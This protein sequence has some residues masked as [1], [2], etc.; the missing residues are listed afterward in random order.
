M[1]ILVTGG[2]GFI[3]SHVVDAYVALGHEVVVMDD[4]SSGRRENINQKAKVLAVDI[5]ATEVDKIFEDE[6][7][8]AI[9][10]HAA[11]IHVG[12]SVADPAHDAEINI[13]GTINLMQA[14]VKVGTIK[15]VIF[16]STGGAMYGNKQTPFVET[17]MPA[18]LSPYGVS[19]RAAE[20]YLNFYWEQYHIPFVALR[21]ANVYGPRQNPY[22]EA[23]VVAIFCEQLLRGQRTTI[24]GDGKQ[25]RDYVFV[26]D[27]VEANQQALTA[28]PVGVFNIGTGKE[29]DVN[30]IYRLVAE[31]LTSRLS[32]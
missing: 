29:T 31:A 18:P 20:L 16:A 17:M 2:A 6:R 3:G 26:K 4:F 32:P 22:G 9:N 23:G 5:R 7:F 30:E 13:L 28:K 21:Y 25:T 15:K 19:K 12:R 11:H 10:H 8:D 24:F 14:A 27:V 1:K